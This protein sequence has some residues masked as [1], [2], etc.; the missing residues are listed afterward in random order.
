MN[1]QDVR[2]EVVGE[3]VAEKPAGEPPA[4]DAA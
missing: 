4:V 1:E 3:T 2:V